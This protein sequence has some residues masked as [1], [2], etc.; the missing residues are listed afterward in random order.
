MLLAC[1]LPAGDPYNST[2]MEASAGGNGEP[3]GALVPVAA[4]ELP[5]WCHDWLAQAAVARDQHMLRVQR[6]LVD[7][8][9]GDQ[10]TTGKAGRAAQVRGP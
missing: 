3:A 2:I 7:Q 6:L 4:E 10:R 9:L 1:A 8:R 5:R